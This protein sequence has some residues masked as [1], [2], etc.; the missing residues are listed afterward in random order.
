[1]D[2]RIEYVC[3]YTEGPL[4]L[5]L[6]AVQHDAA[7]ASN[8][9]WLHQYLVNQFERVVGV[10]ILADDVKQLNNQGYEMIEADVTDMDLGITADT[11]VAGELIEHIDNPGQFLTQAKQHL[12]PEGNL[13]LTTPNPWAIVHLR[14]WVTGTYS[15]NPTH[16]AWY[17][18][19]VLT[20]LLDRYGFTV[21]K[22]HTTER[23]HKGLTRVAQ[24]LG[25]DVFGG[26]TWICVA[27]HGN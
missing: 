2:N 5:D 27:T 4:V 14:R 10:D 20:Q 15:I 19:R 21:T 6:G 8:T 16:V 7:N 25:S 22:L 23:D 1:M 26:T 3:E 9:E 18:P 24:E 17:G 13:I 11:I 12:K